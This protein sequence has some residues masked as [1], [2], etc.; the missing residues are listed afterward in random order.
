[1]IRKVANEPFQASHWVV[2][3]G[4]AQFVKVTWELLMRGNEC[5]L[6]WYPLLYQRIAEWSEHQVVFEHCLGPAP[7]LYVLS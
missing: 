4:S 7:M 1:M 2:Q 3:N 6:V 5:W